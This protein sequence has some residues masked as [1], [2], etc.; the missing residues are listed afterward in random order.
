MINLRI[1]MKHRRVPGLSAK[2]SD[3]KGKKAIRVCTTSSEKNRIIVALCCNA[4]GKLL[5]PIIIFKGKTK[6]K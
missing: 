2:Q 5:P 3:C 6:R 1:P 4:A